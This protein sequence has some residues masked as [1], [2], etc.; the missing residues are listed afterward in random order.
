MR[1]RGRGSRGRARRVTSPRTWHSF[2]TVVFQLSGWVAFAAWVS[3]LVDPAGRQRQRPVLVGSCC[4]SWER[5]AVRSCFKPS[6]LS[7]P[8]RAFLSGAQETAHPTQGPDV[9]SSLRPLLLG[10]VQPH[11][12]F[13][14]TQGDP[15]HHIPGLSL[16]QD[17]VLPRSLGNSR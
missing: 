6:S 1:G 11:L 17:Q 14:R 15:R 13:L 16:P 10:Q 3:S 12:P 7:P 9:Q 8:S 2:C 5:E 4:S